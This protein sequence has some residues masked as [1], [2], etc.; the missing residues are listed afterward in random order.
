MP[1]KEHKYHYIYKTTCNVT[2]RFY[3]GMHS[4]SNLEDGYLGSG[5]RLRRSLYKHG[6]ENHSKEILEFLPNREFL[7]LREKELINE[8]LLK[9]SLCMNLKEGGEGGS[10]SE[11]NGF[12][13]KKHK[14]EII[15]HIMKKLFEV[16]RD[17]IRLPEIQRRRQKTLYEKYGTFAFPG[18]KGL[19]HSEETKRKM[20]NKAK[21]RTPEQNSQYGTI[22][23]HNLDLKE[24]KK[25]KK[26]DF[27]NY[28][29]W[30]KGRKMK[31]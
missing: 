2:R 6:K 1:R 11:T 9:D 15:P 25:I 12:K 26:E 28:S 5:K 18:F 24:N 3:I 27:I 19:N 30:I 31:F 4:T 20:S 7:K 14:R 16:L 23:I 13:G 17:P 8:D 21:L 29:T 22:W 10:S